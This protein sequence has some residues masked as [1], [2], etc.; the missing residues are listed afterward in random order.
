MK[1]IINKMF[2]V[3]LFFLLIFSGEVFAAYAR[4]AIRHL[5]QS[6]NFTCI[7][8]QRGQSWESLFP[9]ANTRDAVMRLNR[10]NVWLQPGMVIAV[11]DR[12]Y[13]IDKMDF[14]PLAHQ[15]RPTGRK[16]IIVDPGEFAFGAY[17]AN[18]QLVRWGPVS[19]GQGWCSDIHRKCRS[20]VGR[21]AVYDK[22]GAKCVSTKFPIG[23]G[24]APM[25]Y[26]M[27][28]RGGYA[29]HGSPLVPGYHA[30][31]GCIRLFT[32]DARWLNQEFID[33]GTPVIVRPYR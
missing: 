17:N 30:S 8:V 5:C 23:K 28:F 29:L 24:G 4:P 11:P 33:M 1:T 19:M 6:S 14:A 25:P 22:R 32:Q 27:F 18:G 10:M 20:P 16:T 15:I 13:N 12:L 2:L 31:H 26:C 7:R 3:V 21:F 9:N